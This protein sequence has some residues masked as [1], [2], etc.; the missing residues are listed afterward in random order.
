MARNYDVIVNT[1]GPIFHGGT[2]AR[3]LLDRGIFD[4]QEA[5]GEEGVNQIHIMLGS[6]LQ[7]PTGFYESQIGT[8]WVSTDLSV[9]DNDV[10]YGPWLEG[11]S[12]RNQTTLFPGYSTFR[13]VTQDLQMQAGAI[14]DVML[15]P[16]IMEIN[17]GL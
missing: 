17:V 3:A 1:Y 14:A 7:N 8:D 11:T 5:I 4:A 16:Y 6:V 15:A 13:Y 2:R 10:I 9:N 12:S